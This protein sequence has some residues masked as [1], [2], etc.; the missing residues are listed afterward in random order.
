MY[1]AAAD[2]CSAML[3]KGTLSKSKTL[4]YSNKQKYFKVLYIRLIIN[5]G[6]LSIPGEIDGT[7]QLYKGIQAL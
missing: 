6:I 4:P 1:L 7:I 2:Q 5:G 3:L